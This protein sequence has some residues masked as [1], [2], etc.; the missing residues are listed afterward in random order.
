MKN[1]IYLLIMISII[2]AHD[3]AFSIDWCNNPIILDAQNEVVAKW[4]EQ[5][6]IELCI[7]QKI[8]EAEQ[9]ME[10]QRRMEQQLQNPTVSEPQPRTQPTDENVIYSKSNN[11]S[12]DSKK[13]RIEKDENGNT[14]IT[15]THY[16]SQPK[17]T[18]N[19]E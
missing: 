1:K 18:E 14:V 10:R 8:R 13:V 12:D 7:E 9:K 4:N 19:S 3:R 11:N 5:R 2:F 15:N 17:E 16:N 6:R